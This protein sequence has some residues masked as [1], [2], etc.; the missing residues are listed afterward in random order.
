[1][2]KDKIEKLFEDDQMSSEEV[3]SDT[4]SALLNL[5]KS[6]GSW[7]ARDTLKKLASLGFWKKGQYAAIDMNMAREIANAA[8]QSINNNEIDVNDVYDI[9]YSWAEAQ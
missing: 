4:I 2:L 3:K 1:M 8:I 5:R 9:V 6:V 7:S